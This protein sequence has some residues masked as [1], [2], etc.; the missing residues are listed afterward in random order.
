MPFSNVSARAMLSTMRRCV[1]CLC[2]AV[3]KIKTKRR[4]RRPPLKH[5]DVLGE[6]PRSGRHKPPTHSKQPPTIKRYMM[7]IK[8]RKDLA[9]EKLARTP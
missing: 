5:R 3:P 6:T 4:H 1:C 7:S 8:K 2:S 9:L